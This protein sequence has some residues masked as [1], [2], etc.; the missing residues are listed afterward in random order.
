MR[1]VHVSCWLTLYVREGA[2]V[3]VGRGPVG[4]CG[5]HLI[6]PIPGR[7]VALDID[8]KRTSTSIGRVNGVPQ[9]V[10]IEASIRGKKHTVMINDSNVHFS[11]CVD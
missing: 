8:G 2:M 4:L 1:G 6:R 11:C 7:V 3:K 9:P 10:Y 5:L